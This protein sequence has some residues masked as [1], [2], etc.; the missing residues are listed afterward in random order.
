M[1]HRGQKR[2]VS[3]TGAQSLGRP[4][5]EAELARELGRWRRLG[6]PGQGPQWDGLFLSPQLSGVLFV[7]SVICSSFAYHLLS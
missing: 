3:W 4:R 6:M 5:A 2:S 1:T 7:D